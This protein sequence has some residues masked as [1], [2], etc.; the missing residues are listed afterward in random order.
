MKKGEKLVDLSSWN[1]PIN[2]HNLHIDGFTGVILRASIGKDND[3]YFSEFYKLAKAAGLKVGA[4]HYLK[5][6]SPEELDTIKNSSSSYAF[7]LPFFI[8][9]E[10]RYFLEK[11]ETILKDVEKAVEYVECSPGIYASS[12]MYKLCPSLRNIGCIWEANWIE[13]ADISDTNTTIHQYT[14]DC[15][16]IGAKTPERA[17]D[18]NILLKDITAAGSEVINIS[19]TIDNIIKELIK[20]KGILTN[21]N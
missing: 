8:D 19:N 18:A 11:P 16:T 2:F 4:Y 9:V 12:S 15:H 17:V 6:T 7:D 14:N 10:G 1:Y 3:A 21:E 13:G 20:I 5:G